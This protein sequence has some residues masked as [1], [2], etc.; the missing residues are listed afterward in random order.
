MTF[1]LDA[2][3]VRVSC[4]SPV[5]TQRLVEKGARLVDP[6]QAAYLPAP[7]IPAG[8]PTSP[9]PDDPEDPRT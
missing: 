7:E 3:G 1:E 2:G 4:S 5:W 6:S 9:R 8:A